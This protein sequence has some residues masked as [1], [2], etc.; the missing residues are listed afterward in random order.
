MPP[1]REPKPDLVY[2]A[3]NEMS[4]DEIASWLKRMFCDP[5][6][7]KWLTDHNC[8]GF[9]SP[10]SWA[11]DVVYGAKDEIKNLF[12]E[13]LLK[14]FDN[15]QQHPE[16]WQRKK[17]SKHDPA[18]RG[19]F[20]P[21]RKLIDFTEILTYREDPEDPEEEKVFSEAEKKRLEEKFLPFLE[22]PVS[23][24]AKGILL[25]VMIDQQSH[26]LPDEFWLQ[27]KDEVPH[28]QLIIFRG[29]AMQHPEEAFNFLASQWPLKGKSWDFSYALAE[30]Q[31]R[32]GAA[33]V[34]QGVELL[35]DAH[36]QAQ[37]RLAYVAREANRDVKENQR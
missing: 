21:A 16:D 1:L 2:D 37:R 19:K 28:S 31:T 9:K 17:H 18:E 13:A 10:I 20:D 14:L 22:A 27:W 5:E 7:Y 36:P 3:F 11:Q 4:A 12:A 15:V 33:V 23:S 6:A 25:Q 35:K 8:R 32:H 29:I 24:H 30:V 26:K 34:D